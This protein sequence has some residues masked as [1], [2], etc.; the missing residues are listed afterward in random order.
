MQGVGLDRNN[1]PAPALPSLAGN[2]FDPE[3]NPD[4]MGVGF[5]QEISNE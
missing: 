4:P 2:R 3:M 5:L 1:A